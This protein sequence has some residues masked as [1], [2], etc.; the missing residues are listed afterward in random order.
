MTH[1]YIIDATDAVIGDDFDA[2]SWFGP[3][4]REEIVR[5]ADCRFRGVGS[6]GVESPPICKRPM[7]PFVVAPDGFC[8]WGRAK[9]MS[10]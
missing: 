6:W 2:R 10:E 5:C 7:H 9:V 8:A 3:R 4:L 1:E